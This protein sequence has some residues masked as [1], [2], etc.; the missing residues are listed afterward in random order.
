MP[1]T[2][3]H[4]SHNNRGFT[5]LELLVVMLVIT[6][7]YTL[8]SL[9]VATDR[10]EQE[11]ENTVHRLAEV[12]EFALEEAELRG[13]DLGLLLVRE[14]SYEG[15]VVHYHWRERQPLGWGPMQSSIEVFA[16]RQF[17]VGVDVSLSLENIDGIDLPTLSD[18]EDPSPQLVFHAAGE[19]TPGSIDLIVGDSGELRW[20]LE[21]DLLGRQKLLS[22]GEPELEAVP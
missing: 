13:V 11:L 8:A 22:R 15:T 20:R 17:P 7:V 10:G 21:W 19:T 16:P 1:A 14:S 3:C 6:L 18:S 5:L 2:G 9:G 12:A 4:R